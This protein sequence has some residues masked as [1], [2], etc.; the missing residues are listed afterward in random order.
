MNGDEESTTYYHSASPS[1]YKGRQWARETRL[2]NPVS[3]CL[4]RRLHRFP[5]LSSCT[6]AT[7]LPACLPTCLSACAETEAEVEESGVRVT[8]YRVPREKPGTSPGIRKKVI[9]VNSCIFFL[10]TYFSSSFELVMGKLFELE[11]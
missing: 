4:P 9:L 2:F 5:D 7:N 1:R 11:G 3:T 10:V 8:S 6:L